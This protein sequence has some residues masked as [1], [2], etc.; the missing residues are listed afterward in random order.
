MK[1]EKQYYN[2]FTN[3]NIDASKL[4]YCVFDRNHS[5]TGFMC[6]CKY[7]KDANKIC[8]LLNERVKT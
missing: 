4:K 1:E 7:R 3:L 6:I 2:V 8:K 5:L